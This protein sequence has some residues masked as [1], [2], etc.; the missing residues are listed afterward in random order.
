MNIEYK[1]YKYNSENWALNS[2]NEA[3][4]AFCTLIGCEFFYSSAEINALIA[5][6]F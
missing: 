4:A 5:L 6:T 2:K 1:Y 3:S